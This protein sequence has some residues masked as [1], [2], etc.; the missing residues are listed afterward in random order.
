MATD[1]TGTPTALGIPKFNVAVDAPS[2][3]GTNAMM[4]SIDA[5]LQGRVAKPAS[6]AAGEVP[7]WNG[8]TWVRS[9]TTNIGPTSLGSG[10]PDTTKFLRGDGS[11]QVV[12]SGPT[13]TYATTPPGSPASG[14]IWYAVDS[15]TSPT[16]QWTF[17]WN[18]G[19]S[20]TDKWEF[21]GGSPALINIF[22]SEATTS[23]GYVALTTAGPS[24][25]C[26]RAGVYEVEIGFTAQNGGASAVGVMSYD[27][28]GTGAVDG[29]AALSPANQGNVTV[30]NAKTQARF[31]AGTTALVSKYRVAVAGTGT[32]ERRWMR[33]VPV[34]VT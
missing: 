27:I 33:V 18:N 24:F 12:S 6:I 34:R 22:T 31:T 7:V 23:G 2:G 9:T 4:D 3:L 13:I 16:Y 30:S 19:S 32:F 21:V 26:P 15:T 29:D 8:S 1:A 5:L 14:D 28:G 25:T 10:T 17:R 20:N 11:W